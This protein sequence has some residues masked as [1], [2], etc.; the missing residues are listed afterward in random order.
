MPAGDAV[1]ELLTCC[2]CGAWAEAVVAGR[3]YGTLAALSDAAAGLIH[4]LDWDGILAA[5]SAHPRIGDRADGE[6]REA[7]WSRREQAGAHD[8]DDEVRAALVAGNRRYEERFGHVF[9]I[10][11][12]GRPAAGML[13]ELRRRLDSDVADERRE[14]RRQLAEITRLR[15]AGLLT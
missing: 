2:R 9:L 6:H 13:A 7:R 8:A 1:R 12:A 10:R 4:D 14:V 3:P 11:A 5:L 15:L